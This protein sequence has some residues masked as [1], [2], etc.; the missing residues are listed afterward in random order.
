MIKQKKNENFIKGWYCMILFCPSSTDHFCGRSKKGR[1]HVQALLWTIVI[2]HSTKLRI[3]KKFQLGKNIN[4]FDWRLLNTNYSFW[5]VDN[6]DIMI[7]LLVLSDGP[8]SILLIFWFSNRALNLFKSHEYWQGS[9]TP[10][11][12]W[13]NSFENK[14]QTLIIVT[15]I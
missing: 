2:I 15:M 10:E 4:C 12:F 14:Y 5:V 13:W 1:R 9:N 6:G 7:R 3:M 8:I 11:S